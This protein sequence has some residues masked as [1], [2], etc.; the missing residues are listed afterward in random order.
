[1]SSDRLVLVVLGRQGSGKGT[2]SALLV[3][4]YGCVHVSTGDM[5]RAAVEAGSELGRQAEAIMAA[6]DLV[7]DGVMCGIVEQRLAEADIR[8]NGVLLDGFPRTPTQADALLEMLGA[9]GVD[10]AV[11][12]DVP[13]AEVTQRMVDRGREDDTLD[14]ISR[15]LELYEAQTAPLLAWFEDHGL[16]HTVD[17]MGTREDVFERVVTVIDS[18]A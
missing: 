17:G 2:Q 4:K 6:G 7:P 11:N 10:L 3:D 13:V 16:L 8:E 1:M 18:V 12:I 9:E 14:A 15:R 5:L